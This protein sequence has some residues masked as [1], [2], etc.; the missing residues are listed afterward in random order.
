MKSVENSM[1]SMQSVALVG[2]WQEMTSRTVQPATRKYYNIQPATRY[3]PLE[4]LQCLTRRYYNNKALESITQPPAQSAQANSVRRAVAT[5]K[6]TH[7]ESLAPSH[8]PDNAAIF[9]PPLSFLLPVF[10]TGSI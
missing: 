5:R 1:H 10:T 3:L 9:W 6:A 4:K 2:D 8:R 7:R